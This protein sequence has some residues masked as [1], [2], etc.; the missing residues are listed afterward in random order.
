MRENRKRS[1]GLRLAYQILND[2]RNLNRYA[3]TSLV[4]NNGN[5]LA[6]IFDAIDA[7]AEAFSEDQKGRE[8]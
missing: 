7:V 3:S 5:H 8:G 1:D 2:K 6:G 4:D